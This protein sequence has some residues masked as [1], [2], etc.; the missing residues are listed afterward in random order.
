MRPWYGRGRGSIPRGGSTPSV[1]SMQHAGLLTRVVVV[2]VH[3]EGPWPCSPSGQRQQVESLSSGGS[4]P[5]VATIGS[6]RN[7]QT[8]HAQTVQIGVRIPASRPF[9]A[10]RK[11]LT[12][13]AQDRRACGFESHRWDHPEGDIVEGK[14]SA[15][16]AR[17]YGFESRCPRQDGLVVQREDPW[18]APRG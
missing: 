13:P 18:P 14:D 1:V 6:W 15:L 3:P 5:P 2:R 8:R 11:W 16:S 17:Q 4:S 12:P 9:P 7:W 10:W